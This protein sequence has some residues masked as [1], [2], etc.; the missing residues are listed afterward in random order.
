MAAAFTRIQKQPTDEV[1]FLSDEVGFLSNKVGSLSDTIRSWTLF[2]F[3]DHFVR[4]ACFDDV[5]QRGVLRLAPTDEMVNEVFSSTK[6]DLERA[7]RYLRHRGWQV[8]F[9]RN[10]TD[11]DDK[12]IERAQKAGEDWLAYAQRYIDS[13]HEDM[14]TSP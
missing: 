13:Y 10:F 12:I 14:R 7:V 1:G 4:V 11:V 6:L 2:G 3:V 9:V 8:K 5:G